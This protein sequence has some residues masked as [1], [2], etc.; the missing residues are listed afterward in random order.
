MFSD[1]TREEAMCQQ[2]LAYSLTATTPKATEI[3]A[4]F[5]GT[6]RHFPQSVLLFLEASF[7]QPEGQDLEEQSRVV[8]EEEEEV[9]GSKNRFR[10]VKRC[11]QR[12]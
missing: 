3:A 9:D 2:Q 4:P 8:K 10:E 7:M 5:L 1:G 12:A 11:N 6:C